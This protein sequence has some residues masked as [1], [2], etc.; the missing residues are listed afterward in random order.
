MGSISLLVAVPQANLAGTTKMQII[1]L[2]YDAQNYIDITFDT[3]AYRFNGAYEAGNTLKSVNSGL[4]YNVDGGPQY[5]EW[6][7]FGLSWTSAGDALKFYVDGL[8]QGSTQTSLGTWT[9]AMASGTMVLGSS[10][11]SSAADVLTGYI[12]RVGIW[13]VVLPAATMQ[14]LAVIGL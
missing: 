14:D 6:H 3:T 10:S 12:A 7:H 4:V 1:T 13:S 2:N 8:Q 9:G 5:P 11:S